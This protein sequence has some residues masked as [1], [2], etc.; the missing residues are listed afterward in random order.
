MGRYFVGAYAASPCTDRWQPALESELFDG[1]A[2]AGFVSGLEL[3]FSGSLH[4]DVDWLMR[5]IRPD[6]SIVLTCIPGT[7]ERLAQDA[8]FGLASSSEAGRRRA[9]DF[10]AAARNSVEQLE[11]GLGRRAVVA[12]EIHSAPRP[13]PSAEPLSDAFRRSL[14]ELR[15]WDWRGAALSVEH[16]DAFV[17]GQAPSK[18]FLAIGSEIDAILASRG[19]TPIGL[20]V[21]WGRSA[22]EARDPGVPELHVRQARLRGVLNGLIFSG[23]TIGDPLYGDWADRHAPFAASAADEARLLTAARA[24]ACLDAAQGPL[25]FLGFKIQTLPKTL[26]VAER[27]AELKRTADLLDRVAA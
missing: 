11:Q 8:E 6:W 17:P 2:A 22:I 16:C 12:V 7:M 1:L 5:S 23:A 24:K 26:T 14:D 15:G 9:L 3:P 18:G 13:A 19:A 20:A 4:R 10:A 25:A 21:N 27:L